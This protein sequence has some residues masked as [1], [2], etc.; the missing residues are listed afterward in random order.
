[1]PR[2]DATVTVKPRPNTR[3]R[4]REGSAARFGRITGEDPAPGAGMFEDPSRRVLISEKDL[5]GERRTNSFVAHDPHPAHGAPAAGA[6]HPRRSG[7]L[8]R[9]VPER[10]GFAVDGGCSGHR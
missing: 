4:V 7:G 10:E 8:R 9:P 1:M 2:P 3:L 6:V 5:P